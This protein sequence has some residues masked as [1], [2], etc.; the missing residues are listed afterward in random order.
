MNK[1][2]LTTVVVVAVLIIG[3]YYFYQNYLNQSGGVSTPTTVTAPTP[4]AEGTG[5]SSVSTVKEFTVT[6]SPF[7]FDPAN[8]SV[9][10]GDLVKITF[11]N[12]AGTHN[13][14]VDEFNTKTQVIQAGQSETVEFTADQVGT[15]EYY[16]A[17]GN[18]RA[19]GMVGKLVVQ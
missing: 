11:N 4:A 3:G 14:V 16:C 12:S 18:H 9:N 7:K 2:L 1:N 17:V 10:K 19:Q 6:G 5:S 15:F 8:I 13:W